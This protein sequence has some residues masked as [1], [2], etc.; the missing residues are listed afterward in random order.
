MISR[1]HA[2]GPLRRRCI[3]A[4]RAA[5]G[6]QFAAPRRRVAGAAGPIW[7]CRARRA[8][9]STSSAALSA[10]SSPSA[11]TSRSRSTIKAGIG[12][13]V[14]SEFVARANPDGYTLYITAA[15]LVINQF[16]MS[17]TSYNPATDFAPVTLVG[18]FPNL[19]VVPAASPFRSIAELIGYAKSHPGQLKFG[20]TG[21]GSSPHI[22]G[23]LF[24]FLADIELTHVPYPDVTTS[25]NDLMAAPI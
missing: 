25:L 7:S 23:E 21:Y 17:E 12:G 8:A 16:M 14:A 22:S 19:M 4:H 3:G 13:N 18:L 2:I 5:Q 6:R 11:G 20:S 9:A 15:G 1:R 10:A 24:K